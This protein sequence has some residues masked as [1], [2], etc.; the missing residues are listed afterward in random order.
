MD[1]LDEQDEGNNVWEHSH[2]AC[3]V[4][5]AMSDTFPCHIFQ[6]FEQ[7]QG[8]WIFSK[9]HWVKEIKGIELEM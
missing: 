4:P 1:G 5:G 3:Y 9:G 6:N 7:K 2:N 8:G